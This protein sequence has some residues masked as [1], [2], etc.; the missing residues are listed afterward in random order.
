ML[1]DRFGLNSKGETRTLD[2]IG[3]EYGIT[4]ER[5]RQI[6]NHGLS[7]VRDSD[8]YGTHVHELDEMKRAVAALGGLLAQETILTELS[9]HPSDQNHL[10][11]LLTVGTHF[12]D[13]RESADFRD[14]W[15]IDAQLAESVEAALSN[16]YE[17]IEANRL[18][19]EEEFLRY[20]RNTSSKKA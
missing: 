11:F 18:T 14:R 4:R 2:A 6:E 9:K 10:V 19:P 17:S 1:V 20:L 12:N 5:I 7:S 16:L 8:A 15:H 3:K 13:K